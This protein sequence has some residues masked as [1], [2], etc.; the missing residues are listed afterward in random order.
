MRTDPSVV[1]LL[2]AWNAQPFIQDT[3][4]ALS[5][6]TYPNFKVVVS[7][8]LSTDETAAICEAHSRQDPR[9]RIMRQTS[10]QGFVGNTARL[11]RE[12]R[13]DYLMWAWHDDLVEPQYV[14][15]LVSVI[16]NHPRAVSVF[17]DLEMRHLDGHVQTLTYE[18]LEGVTD[19][20]E[21]AKR[22]IWFPENWALP[23]RGLYRL[24]GARRV[25]GFKRHWAGEYVCD[26]PWAVHMAILGEHIRVPEVLCRKFLKVTSLSFSW[27][28]ARWKNVAVTTSVAREIRQSDLPIAKKARLLL[29]VAGMLQGFLTMRPTQWEGSTRVQAYHRDARAAERRMTRGQER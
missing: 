25:G 5:R 18:A 12:A 3:L 14:T 17:T 16:E 9:F 13:A 20:V 1:A 10:R 24:S 23:N 7:V 26:W 15:R 29:T 19:P 6:Q 28:R 22:V 8:D 2:P 21:R 27:H 4:D 11:L